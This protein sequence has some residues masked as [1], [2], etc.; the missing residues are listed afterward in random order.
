MGRCA[1]QHLQYFHLQQRKDG[2]CYSDFVGS[3]MRIWVCCHYPKRSADVKAP[4]PV[5]QLFPGFVAGGSWEILQEQQAC[6]HGVTLTSSTSIGSSS[7]SSSSN[8]RYQGTRVPG[9]GFPLRELSNQSR[10]EQDLLG[11]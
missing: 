4:T 2:D 1:K 5:Y 3:G 7:S 11:R 10:V 9:Y 8:A 6:I